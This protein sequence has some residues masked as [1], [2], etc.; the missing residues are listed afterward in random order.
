MKTS[1]DFTTEQK[2]KKELQKIDNNLALSQMTIE[3]TIQTKSIIF[4]Q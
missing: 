2:F 1:H 3:Q 4:K